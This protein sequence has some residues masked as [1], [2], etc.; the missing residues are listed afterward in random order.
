MG[1]LHRWQTTYWGPLARGHCTSSPIWGMNASVL[2]LCLPDRGLAPQVELAN[3]SLQSQQREKNVKSQREENL[4]S[5][6]QLIIN[7][8]RFPSISRVVPWSPQ[9]YALALWI[10]KKLFSFSF[11][12][13]VFSHS[14]ASFPLSIII[15]L[16]SFLWSFFPQLLLPSFYSLYLLLFHYLFWSILFSLIVPL[17]QLYDRSALTQKKWSVPIRIIQLQPRPT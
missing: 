2:F 12:C 10:R 8:M 4:N 16:H 1:N 7:R 3:F 5:I 13:H 6:L 17:S 11:F 15:H 14:F 9:D